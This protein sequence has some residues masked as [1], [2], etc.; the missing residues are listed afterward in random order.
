M[1]N[2]AADK[3]G[4]YQ[5]GQSSDLCDQYRAIGIPAINAAALCKGEKRQQSQQGQSM[6]RGQYVEFED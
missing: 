1:N 3:D 4:R 5:Q 6:P 2:H